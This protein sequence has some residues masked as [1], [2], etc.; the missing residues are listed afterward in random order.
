MTIWNKIKKCIS[1]DIEFI[2]GWGG[3]LYVLFSFGLWLPFRTNIAAP[4]G[5]PES[6]EIERKMFKAIFEH[7][8]GQIQI[9]IPLV[10]ITYI[11]GALI[12]E[13]SGWMFEWGWADA[14]ADMYKEQSI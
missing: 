11:W 4:V 13:D 10:R 2:I 14:N 7:Q 8:E 6:S 12:P 5:P 1:T 9:T 3:R